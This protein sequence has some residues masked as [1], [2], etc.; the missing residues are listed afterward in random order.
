MRQ[1]PHSYF[2]HGRRWRQQRGQFRDRKAGVTAGV[3]AGVRRKVHL[4]VQ[5]QP[6]VTAATT[7]TQTQC[8]QFRVAHIHA[9]RITPCHRFNTKA[10][11]VS[12]DGLL[13]GS[14]QIAYA[15]PQTA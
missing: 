2:A 13:D 7:N 5:R 14:H 11:D 4:H 9:R 1:Q 12:D 8:R 6:V 10:R 3:D 15:E